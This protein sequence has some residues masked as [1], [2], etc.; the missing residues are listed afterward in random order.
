MVLDERRQPIGVVTDRD[1]VVRVIGSGKDPE[2]TP[3]GVVMTR[4][5]KVV[6]EDSP[7]ESA[8]GLMRAAGFRRV[9]V[10]DRQGKLVGILSL[11]DVLALLAEE[12]AHIGAIVNRQNAAPRQAAAANPAPA[13]RIGKQGSRKR[14]KT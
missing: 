4:K 8:L 12:F 14:G 2:T 11:D 10:V 1:L 3:V 6:D 7:I 9:P 5:P 13:P